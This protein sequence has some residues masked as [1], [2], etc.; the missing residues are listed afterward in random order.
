MTP[1]EFRAT[2][3][4]LGISC[5]WISRW[6]DIN[7]R[8]VRKWDKG[9]NNVP[10]P[11]AEWLDR[12]AKAT[13][14]FVSKAAHK[15]AMDPTWEFGVPRPKKEKEDRKL[16]ELWGGW[17]GDWWWNVAGRVLDEDR[18]HRGGALIYIDAHEGEGPTMAPPPIP[19]A[20][21]RGSHPRR[22]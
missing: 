10:E 20:P 13:E 19:P 11:I 2:R 21:E 14:L 3:E 16:N 22:F 18:K 9:D 12:I 7:D 6:G 17:P 15:R 5:E 8:S 4:Y 1:A